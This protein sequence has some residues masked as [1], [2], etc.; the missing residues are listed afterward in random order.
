MYY[1]AAEIQDERVGAAAT[2][3]YQMTTGIVKQQAIAETQTCSLISAELK[4]ILYAL[5]HARDTLRKKAHVYVAT[6]SREALSAIEKGHKVGYGREVVLKIADAVL[7]MESVGHR[8]TAFLVPYDKDI[9][10]V[11]EAKEA[12]TSAIDNGSDLTAAPAERVRE[13]SGVLRLVKAERN[14]GLHTNED[15]VYVK[16]YT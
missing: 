1:A 8:V 4:A 10:G 6:M 3:K 9:C 13:L 15:D 2:I 16:Y 5:E 11:T 12:A 14:K 7:E